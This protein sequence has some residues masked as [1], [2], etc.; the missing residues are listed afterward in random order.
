MPRP[1]AA[2]GAVSIDD[3]LI[4]MGGLNEEEAL[5]DVWMLDTTK[6]SAEWIEKQKMPQPRFN[7]GITKVDGKIFIC[8]GQSLSVAMR[9]V[10]I[11]DGEV[12]RDGSKLKS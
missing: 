6:E 9:S 3:I 1:N 5:D 12:W 8:G 10:D 4:V 7:F 11:F 2:F